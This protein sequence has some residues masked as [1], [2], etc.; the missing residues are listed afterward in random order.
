MH[1]TTDGE[2]GLAQSVCTVHFGGF[3]AHMT[4]WS[5]SDKFRKSSR[6]RHDAG[7]KTPARKSEL[8]NHPGSL[9]N[10]R[11]PLS[12]RFSHAAIP[13]LRSVCRT[14]VSRLQSRFCEDIRKT[15]IPRPNWILLDLMMARVNG[16]EFLQ[17]KS[18]DLLIAMAPQV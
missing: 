7:A 18:S 6:E 13:T 17:R 12:W 10:P 14:R 8:H 4:R 16:W 15:E 1:E 9:Y 2:T 5:D 11:L 3:L